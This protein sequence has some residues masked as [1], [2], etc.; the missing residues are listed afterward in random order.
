MSQR[1]TVSPSSAKENFVLKLRRQRRARA[2]AAAPAR[3]KDKAGQQAGNAYR[4]QQVRQRDGA[5]SAVHRRTGYYF[6]TT[7]K[8]TA[9]S[10]QPND[11]PPTSQ[12]YDSSM[13]SLEAKAKMAEVS[14]LSHRHQMSR[15]SS[16]HKSPEKNKGAAQVKNAVIFRH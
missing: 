4:K 10:L 11:R 6:I 3:A 1:C 8:S 13:S 15:R 12:H 9:E 2:R 5:R 14:L 16:Q 7:P